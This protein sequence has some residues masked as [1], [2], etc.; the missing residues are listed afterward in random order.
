MI[1]TIV[2]DDSALMRRMINDILKEDKDIEVISTASDGE[3]AIKKIIDLKPDVVTLDLEM[4]KL[5]GLDVI[6]RLKNQL[7][8]QDM[9]KIIILSAQTDA[10]K[11]LQALELGAIDFISKPSGN[12]SL[13]LKKISEDIITKIKTAA[14][15]ILQKIEQT[16]TKPKK[17]T[18]YSTRKK[19][20]VIASSTGGPQT[21]EALL[22]QI[23]KNIPA[24]ILIVQHMPA[25]FTNAFAKRLNANCELEIKEAEDG[26]EL[27]DG[28]VLIAPGGYHME[29]VTDIE[30]YEGEIKLNQ[31]PAELGV[32]PNANRLFKSVAKIFQDN[33]IGV[34]LTGMGN[35]GTEGARE[36]KKH[37][38]LIISQSERTSIIY[39][40]PKS[41]ADANLTDMIL[42]LD[43]IP[44]ALLQALDV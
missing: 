5:D 37:S 9:P 3:I 32:R 41:V 16:K 22:R 29:L 44:V 10:E 27:K 4:P 20:I 18:F 13:D 8:E 34:I 11:T 36:I 28:C 6:K 17:S 33:T 25:G 2:V 7:N 12:I 21:L 39:G 35:D 30:G 31:L 40:M 43:N 1:K 15:S 14:K 19:I 38:G 42:D 24:P 26:D 23:P